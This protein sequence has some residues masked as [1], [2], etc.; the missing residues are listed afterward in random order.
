MYKYVYRAKTD[1]FIQR[2]TIP[3][4]VTQEVAKEKKLTLWQRIRLW[5][6]LPMA[7]LLVIAFLIIKDLLR[8]KV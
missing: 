6:F 5:L 8:K 7:M 1:T 2:D 3:Y 4:V